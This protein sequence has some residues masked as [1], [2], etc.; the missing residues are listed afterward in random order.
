LPSASYWAGIPGHQPRIGGAILYPNL[1][2]VG[3]FAALT[4][5][6]WWLGARPHRAASTT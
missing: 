5:L 2:V 3:L 6:G 1:V 4:I